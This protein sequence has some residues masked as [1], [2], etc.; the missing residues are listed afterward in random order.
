MGVMGE[1]NKLEEG[2]L[3]YCYI[4]FNNGTIS[5]FNT[6]KV[7][8][9][10]GIHHMVK[11]EDTHYTNWDKPIID[12]KANQDSWSNG[13]ST[14][15]WYTTRGY[16]ANMDTFLKVCGTYHKQLLDERKEADNR[17]RNFDRILY[18]LLE[19]E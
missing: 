16:D 17:F 1:L 13:T 10:K 12:G 5:C 6:E 3:Y 4:E 8:C 19:E 18:M 9:G 7:K 2:I 15:S 14:Y 11:F